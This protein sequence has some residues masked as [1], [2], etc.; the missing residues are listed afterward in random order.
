MATIEKRGKKWSVRYWTEDQYGKKVQKRKSGFATKGEAMAAAQGLEQASA[1]GIDIHAGQ[2]TLGELLERWYKDI[3]QTIR[4]TTAAIYS[5]NIDRIKKLPIASQKI[6]S[7]RPGSRSALMSDL[8]KAGYAPST[9]EITVTTVSIAM[10]WAVKTGMIVT[11]TFTGK[12]QHVD[13]RDHVILDDDDIKLLTSACKELMPSFYGPLLMGLYAGLRAGEVMGLTLDDFDFVRKTVSIRRTYILGGMQQEPKTRTSRRTISLPDF[14]L[15]H[16]KTLQPYKGGA[17]FPH[18][19]YSNHLCKLIDKI[20]EAHPDHQLPHM[21]YHDLR[22]T[23]AAMCIR[24][25]IHAKVISER[26]GHSSIS[27]TMDTYG[28]LMPGMQEACAEQIGKLYG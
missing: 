21:R 16:V 24:M 15:D 10:T 12:T 19:N 8:I 18:K 23:H 13:R 4:P 20:N 11:N 6:A 27:I 9:A 25:G 26:L 28:Y 5:T 14:V 1:Q 17:I 2:I 3:Y 22:H 7:L